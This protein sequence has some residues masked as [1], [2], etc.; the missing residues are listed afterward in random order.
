MTKYIPLEEVKFILSHWEQLTYNANTHEEWMDIIFNRVD[1]LPIIDPIATIDEEIQKHEYLSAKYLQEYD[2]E[3]NWV[4]NYKRFHDVE[5][6][7]VMALKD[8]KSRLLT[9]S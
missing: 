2:A 6:W 1:E 3:K 4:I 8:I 9:N 5:E 7:I